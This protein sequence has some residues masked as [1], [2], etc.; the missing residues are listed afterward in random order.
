MLRCSHRLSSKSV[1]LSI[2]VMIFRSL[3]QLGEE[4]HVILIVRYD[5]MECKIAWI[6]N[7]PNCSPWIW[8]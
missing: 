1:L 5:C 8:Y 4:E 3:V 6:Q 2:A 7:A